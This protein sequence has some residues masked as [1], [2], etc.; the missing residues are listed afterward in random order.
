MVRCAC[1][2]YCRHGEC[3]SLLNVLGFRDWG[4]GL[5]WPSAIVIDSARLSKPYDAI[6]T[7]K[8]YGGRVVQATVLCSPIRAN[9]WRFVVGWLDSR[10]TRV[11]ALKQFP[12]LIALSVSDEKSLSK[13]IQGRQWDIV[14]AAEERFQWQSTGNVR[15]LIT[16]SVN[17]KES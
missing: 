7:I 8:T 3:G 2:D 12:Q 15:R 13:L 4:I 9:Q 11:I 14:I 6:K 1:K 10:P 17:R 16:K 5:A